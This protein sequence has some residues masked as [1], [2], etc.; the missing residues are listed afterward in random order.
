MPEGEER[1]VSVNVSVGK[2]IDRS[3]GDLITSLLKPTATELG[4]PMG[5]YIG[6][7]SD[8][9][10]RKRETNASLGMAEVR[11]KLAAADVSPEEI[12]PPKEEDLHLLLTGISLTDDP[13]IRVLWA[14]I[15]TNALDQKVGE[16]PSRAYLRVLQ[17]L[18]PLDAKII[19]FL[20]F[21]IR[22]DA[23]L[24]LSLTD[25]DP[26]TILRLPRRRRNSS[27]PT[28][29]LMRSVHKKRS[30]QSGRR[31]QNPRSTR[32]KGLRGLKILFARG[33]SNAFQRR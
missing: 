27:R 13:G 21:A 11:K 9:I 26:Q 31:P 1:G 19:D 7:A 32:S 25:T 12:A 23:E 30:R 18:S 4:N 2:E 22:T 8:K 24:K 15:F 17:T 20:A 3:I 33:S 16:A 29:K 10:R 28:T 6:L 5:D 14:G